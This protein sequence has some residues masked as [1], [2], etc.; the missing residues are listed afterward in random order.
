MAE[1]QSNA[2][3][4]EQILWVITELWIIKDREDLLQDCIG[5]VTDLNQSLEKPI[6][7]A[8]IIRAF[9]MFLQEHCK[10]AISSKDMAEMNED[11]TKH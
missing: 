10:D 8:D 6:T 11:Y 9:C 7:D 2:S 4:A 3:I 1:D 5:F